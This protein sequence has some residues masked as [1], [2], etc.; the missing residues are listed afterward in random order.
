[1]QTYSTVEVAELL[2]ISWDT[3][4]RWIREKKF[5]APPV[6]S[7][8]RIRVRL[9]AKKDIGK[10]RRYKAKHYRGLGSKKPRKKKK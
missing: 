10:V 7:L 4:N 1:M 5:S 3:I 9:W 6:Q 8:G 2:D